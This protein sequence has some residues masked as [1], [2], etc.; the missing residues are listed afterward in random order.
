LVAV[1]IATAGW[2]LINFENISGGIRLV[3]ERSPLWQLV[4]L[5]GPQL[6]IGLLLWRRMN[7]KERALYLTAIAL[8]IIPEVVYV[9]DIY[10]GHLRANTMFKLTFQAFV[11]LMVLIAG[12]GERRWFALLLLPFLVYGYFGY[13][14]FYGF[15]GAGSLN[16]R[17]FMHEKSVEDYE[18]VNYLREIKDRVVIVEAVGESYTEFARISTFSGKSTVL[19]WRVHEW[20]WRGGFD[21]VGIRSEEVRELYERPLSREAF[22]IRERYGVEYQ[23]VGKKERKA[24]RVSESE[25]MSLG[26]RINFGDSYLVRLSER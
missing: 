5:W 26:E 7:W 25:I 18:I 3:E 6:V 12:I 20:L 16:G 2:W 9:K 22:E 15:K 1:A 24:Y 23:V 10:E 13:A 19:G 14:G 4:V 21:E 17:L 8:L 11:W